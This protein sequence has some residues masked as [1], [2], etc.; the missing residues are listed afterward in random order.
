V[1]LVDVLVL[2]EPSAFDGCRVAVRTV[3]VVLAG[4]TQEGETRRNDR[5]IGPAARSGASPDSS[6]GI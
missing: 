1:A 5:L 4:R 3:G 6:G 2:L